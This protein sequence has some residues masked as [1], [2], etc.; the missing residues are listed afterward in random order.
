MI[1]KPQE[2]MKVSPMNPNIDKNGILSFPYIKNVNLLF[3]FFF[4]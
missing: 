3:L 4:F 2:G 1:A